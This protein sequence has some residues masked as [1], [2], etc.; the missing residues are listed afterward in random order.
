MAQEKVK[1]NQLPAEHPSPTSPDDG[2]ART[3]QEIQ[4]SIDEQTWTG[5]AC[6]ER[7]PGGRR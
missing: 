6:I 7:L 3:F 2:N 1:I 5:R 4:Q